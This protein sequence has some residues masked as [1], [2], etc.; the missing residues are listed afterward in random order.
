VAAR[1]EQ[2]ATAVAVV[3]EDSV[4]TSGEIHDAVRQAQPLLQIKYGSDTAALRQ[5]LAKVQ[6]ETIEQMVEDKLILHDFFANPYR[7]NALEDY[8]NKELEDRIR[9]DYY[10]DESRLVRSLHEK[11]LTFESF[12]QMLR[13]RLIIETMLYQNSSHPR[14][15]LISPLKID[16]YYKSHTNKYVMEDQ[17]KLRMIML[18][19]WNGADSAKKVA[20]EILAKLDAGV[21]FAE[22]ASV[23][24]SG[25]QRADGGDC[26]WVNRTY[27]R[28]EI[29]SNAFSLKP[30]QHSDIIELPDA[31][32][33]IMVEEA[34]GAHI[35]PLTEVRNDIE[36]TL[37]NDENVRLKKLW[38]ERLKRK[39]FI[40][41]Y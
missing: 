12:R 4:I 33:L 21:P 3:V 20:R 37:R 30:G 27:F 16:E 35:K 2:L 29:S 6:D 39:S 8:V 25:S 17:V 11:G 13:E 1:S 23:Y 24:S 31:C 41:Y 14:K 34:K 15:I 22:M 19:N 5:D 18:T 28:P 9:R 32:C 38:I 26:G 36:M 40:N 7:T 10:G